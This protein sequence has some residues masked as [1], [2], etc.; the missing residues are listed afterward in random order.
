MKVDHAILLLAH[1]D[2][3]FRLWDA[4]HRY[5]EGVV[6]VA[7]PSE[8]V[9]STLCGLHMLIFVPQ[10]IAEDERLLGFHASLASPDEGNIPGFPATPGNRCCISIETKIIRAVEKGKQLLPR[11]RHIIVLK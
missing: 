3:G 4:L 10:A 7:Y 11:N 9:N 1:R 5:V 2:D 6:Q 8:Q